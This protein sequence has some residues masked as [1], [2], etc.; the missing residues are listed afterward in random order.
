VLD[1]IRGGGRERAG[2][3]S[4]THSAGLEGGPAHGLRTVDGQPI[5]LSPV[6]ARRAP[7]LIDQR[8]LYQSPA[9]FPGRSDHLV[10]CTGSACVSPRGGNHFG[11]PTGPACALS[12]GT[13][14]QSAADTNWPVSS[15]AGPLRL[16]PTVM[17]LT[18]HGRCRGLL[19]RHKSFSIIGFSL[20]GGFV[21]SAITPAFS[22]PSLAPSP[23][24]ADSPSSETSRPVSPLTAYV[25]DPDPRSCVNLPILRGEHT[26]E[27]CV[28]L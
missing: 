22:F 26:A 2:N 13:T 21:S 6:P 8:I 17:Q 16:R 28:W 24:L 11:S 1:P 10:A 20:L 5:G 9:G 25:L 7:I 18:A 23:L 4:P 12:P 15:A 19:G 14:G 3:D 27:V